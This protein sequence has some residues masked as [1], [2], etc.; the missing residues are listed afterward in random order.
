MGVAAAPA[1]AVDPFAFEIGS[2]SFVAGGGGGGGA[3]AA[4]QDPF[5]AVLESNSMGA[6]GAGHIASNMDPFAAIALDS[7]HVTPAFGSTSAG[8]ASSP[9]LTAAADPS[10]AAIAAPTGPFANSTDPFAAVAAV[11]PFDQVASPPHQESPQIPILLD[12]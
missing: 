7:A 10:A 3:A 12:S 1:P 5:A 4:V 11:D 2:D 8:H 6:A 9:P